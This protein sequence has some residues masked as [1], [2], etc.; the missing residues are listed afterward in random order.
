MT[1]HR[2]DDPHSAEYNHDIQVL[3]DLLNSL[4]RTVPTGTRV[5]PIAVIGHFLNTDGTVDNF[6]A[7]WPAVTHASALHTMATIVAESMSRTA[8]YHQTAHNHAL[9]G[10]STLTPDQWPTVVA[11]ERP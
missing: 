8:A 2:E 10:L 11:G 3:Q 4:T 7:T 1:I 9:D 6:L 5:F